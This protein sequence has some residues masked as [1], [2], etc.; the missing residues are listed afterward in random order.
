MAGPVTF[1]RA[2]E[3]AAGADYATD[4]AEAV[5]DAV[6][7]KDEQDALQPHTLEPGVASEP[8]LASAEEVTEL[9]DRTALE[10]EPLET[11]SARPDEQGISEAV[12]AKQLE[13][14]VADLEEASVLPGQE[15]SGAADQ[16]VQP[17]TA[18]ASVTEASVTGHEQQTADELADS[19]APAATSAEIQE[20]VVPGLGV[21]G[22]SDADMTVA[23]AT[24]QVSA[25]PAY[26]ALLSSA[27]QSPQLS[28]IM[29][30]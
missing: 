16:D 3:A 12:T 10:T 19:T 17:N 7:H 18:G 15:Q 29:G 22:A 13:E 25:Q 24:A 9:P 28:H 6:Q 5:L 4:E 30:A 20:T 27:R 21:D 8:S 11:L 23:T 2:M 26:I 14:V 1:A